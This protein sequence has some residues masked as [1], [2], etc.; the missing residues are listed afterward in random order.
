MFDRLRRAIIGIQFRISL[1]IVVFLGGYIFLG[2]V[3]GSKY[4]F[5]DY[6]YDMIMHKRVINVLKN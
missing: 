2:M 5:R 3:K 6:C 4:R 1:I